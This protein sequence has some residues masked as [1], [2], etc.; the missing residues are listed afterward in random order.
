MK[1]N[2]FINMVIASLERFDDSYRCPT[3][4]RRCGV[5]LVGCRNPL[6]VL[7][8]ALYRIRK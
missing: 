6:H 1:R 8:E 5:H 2:K 4:D 3:C 7:H